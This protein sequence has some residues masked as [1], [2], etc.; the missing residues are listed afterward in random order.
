MVQ[1]PYLS[2][3]L[4]LHW[5]PGLTVPLPQACLPACLAL[6]SIWPTVPDSASQGHPKVCFPFAS[7]PQRFSLTIE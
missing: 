2:C 4:A 3:Y 1:A 5:F 6:P 7:Q